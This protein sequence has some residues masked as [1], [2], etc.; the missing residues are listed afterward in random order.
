MASTAITL[1]TIR[2]A[3]LLTGY[4]ENFNQYGH[5][6]VCFIVIGDLKTPDEPNR[7]IMRELKQKWKIEAEYWDVEEQKKWLKSFPKLAEIIPYN[8]DNRRNLGY[9]R[10]AE[11]GANTII[12]IDDDNFV[13]DNDFLAAHSI[14]GQTPKLK[15]VSSSNE[16]FNTCSLLKFNY[17]NQIYPRGYPYHKR[18]N[19][20]LSFGCEEGKV[21]LNMGL[22][23]DAPDVDAVTNLNM[24]IKSLG[25]NSEQLMLGDKNYMPINT[26]NTAFSSDILPCC[27]YLPMGAK[28]EGTILDRYGDIWSGLFINKIVNQ[29]G[30]R[31]TVGHPV[32]RHLRSPH[33]LFKDLQYEL[34]GMILT[35]YLAP[36]IASMKLSKKTYADLYWELAQEVKTLDIYPSADVRKYFQNLAAAMEIW[37]ETCRTIL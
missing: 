29:I 5:H 26:Q 2:A 37:V 35:D 8:S 6:D 19:D 16:W 17:P 32:V 33:D 21:V 12:L 11:L 27:Y 25:I 13:G 23:E 10:A 14:V 24:P 4:A 20:K 34:W 15:T 28:I 31:I 7:Q 22:W 30:D 9:L 18:W 1:T 36:T 3:K